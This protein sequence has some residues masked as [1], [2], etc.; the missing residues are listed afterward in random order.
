M[1]KLLVC[2]LNKYVLHHRMVPCLEMSKNS[3]ADIVMKHISSC[4]LSEELSKA[5]LARK[6]V[7]DNIAMDKDSQM[8][9]HSEDYS[10]VDEENDSSAEE[11]LSDYDSGSEYVVVL[12]EISDGTRL[13]DYDT[14]ENK[15]VDNGNVENLFT[16]TRSGKIAGTWHISSYLSKY[17]YYYNFAYIASKNR[18]NC[19]LLSMNFSSSSKAVYSLNQYEY[20]IFVSL[21]T[22]WKLGIFNCQM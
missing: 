13:D 22:N 18:Q 20:Y 11:Y 10:L 3:K 9:M 5:K 15:T 21:Q 4:L 16:R 19:V 7:H 6:N 8:G 2:S 12:A 14:D 1:K 17:A